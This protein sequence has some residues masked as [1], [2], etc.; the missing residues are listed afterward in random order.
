IVYSLSDKEW[1]KH[2]YRKALECCGDDDAR[3]YVIETIKDVLEDDEWASELSSVFG[4]RFSDDD[5]DEESISFYAG[6]CGEIGC[7]ELFGDRLE[8]F[9][10]LF[11][12]RAIKDSDFIYMPSDMASDYYTGVFVSDEFLEDW[13]LQN[14][15]I[16][17]SGRLGIPNDG[18]GYKPGIYLMYAILGDYSVDLETDGCDEIEFLGPKIDLANWEPELSGEYDELVVAHTVVLDGD[19]K[20]LYEFMGDED[21]MRTSVAIVWVNDDGDVEYLYTYSNGDE[22][23]DPD[24]FSAAFPES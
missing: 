9:K 8:E 12:S 11:I 10:K 1:A 2:V 3:K 18:Q 6:R 17:E 21:D 7:G 15:K 4:I 23:Y 19:E 5:S 13:G 24:V 22:Q 20:E 16:K 14:A